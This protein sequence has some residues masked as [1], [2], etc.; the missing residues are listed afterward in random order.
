MSGI[1]VGS[2]RKIRFG[3]YEV[4]LAVRELRRAGI[5]VKLQDRPF[6]VL[7]I[8][9]ERPGEV[10]T[11]DEFRQRLWPADTLVDF[12]ASLNT[13]VNKLRQALSDNAENPRFIAT[14]GRR[15]YR[16]IAPASAVDD[17]AQPVPA[18]GAISQGRSR[19]WPWIVAALGAGIAAMATIVAVALLRPAWRLLAQHESFTEWKLVNSQCRRRTL[20]KQGGWQYASVTRFGLFIYR[21]GRVEPRLDPNPIP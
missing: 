2:S 14:A 11:R 8:L 18:P 7:A 16:F 12:D 6:E 3:L 19:R 20:A 10:I 9:V 13:S 5:L 21:S 15:G 1:E 17:A 4:D